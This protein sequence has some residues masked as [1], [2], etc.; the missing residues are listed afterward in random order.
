MLLHYEQKNVQ[1]NNNRFSYLLLDVLFWKFLYCL[2]ELFF[3]DV[4]FLFFLLVVYNHA[5]KIFIMICFLALLFPGR[6]AWITRKTHLK[7]KYKI[8]WYF[9]LFWQVC[10]WEKSN[11]AALE[12]YFLTT[13]S[14]SFIICKNNKYIRNCGTITNVFYKIKHIK[15]I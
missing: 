9:N 2:H 7:S 10:D 3:T 12:P 8:S 14:T 6:V 11:L 1:L 15:F 5:L 13:N 4:L